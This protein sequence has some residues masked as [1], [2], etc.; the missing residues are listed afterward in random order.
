MKKFKIVDKVKFYRAIA[1]L[2]ATI[3]V[4]IAL[5]GSITAKA[6]EGED[7]SIDLPDAELTRLLE[8]YDLKVVVAKSGDTFWSLQN[9]E[10]LNEDNRVLYYYSSFINKKP[11]GELMVNEDIL[12]FT[13][14][15]LPNL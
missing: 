2:L 10:N 4:G 5:I 9:A 14:K 12:I 1:I 15:E 11:L 3:I 13:K 7:I 6:Y 8:L